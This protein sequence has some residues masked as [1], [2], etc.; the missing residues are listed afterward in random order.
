MT[1][2]AAERLAPARAAELVRVLDLQSRWE[3]LRAA[4]TP[5]TPQLQALQ[6]AFEAYRVRMAAYAARN[7]GEP[8]PELTPT[9]PGRL[10]TWCKTVRAV[11]RRAE[12]L[13]CP[14]HIVAKA[15]R[16]ADQ[17]AQ[18]LQAEPVV[19]GEPTDVAGAVRELDAVI[20]WCVRLD[21]STRAAAGGSTYEVGGSAVGG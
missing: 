17:I 3:N 14:T 13:E 20:G 10:G 1:E 8:V 9:K 7:Q 16:V 15:Y 19:R 2:A 11:L 5:S 21:G 12:G 6:A 4:G 18:R